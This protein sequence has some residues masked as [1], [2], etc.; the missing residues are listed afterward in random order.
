[1]ALPTLTELLTIPTQDEVLDGE[2][3]PELRA[4]GVRVTDWLPGGVYRSMSYAVARLRLEARKAIAAY[5]AAAF[6]DYVFGFVETPFGIDVTS[7]ATDIA[8]NV[9]GI[10]RIA[11][12]RTKRTITLTNATATPYGPVA[13]GGFIVQL[14]SGNRYV[15]AE[16]W[17]S[18][19]SDAVEVAFESEYANDSAAGLVY[20][21][22]P[23]GATITIVSANF[24]GVTA[25]N[26]AGT[27][28]ARTLVGY[29]LGTVTPSG[30]PGAGYTTATFSVR[31]DSTGQTGAATWSYRIQTSTADTGWVSAGAVAAVANASGSGV[32]ITLTNHATAN[33]S[34][35]AGDYYYFA[36]PGTDIT[37]TGRDEETPLELG[38]RCRAVFPALAFT[39]D[40]AGNWIWT[41]PTENAYERLAREASTQVKVAYARNST[42][43][44]NKVHVLVAGQ[45]T[46]LGAGTVATVQA[47]LDS[48][49]MLTDR[50]VVESPTQ[51]AITLAGMTVTVRASQVTAAQTEIQRR[52]A[53]YLGGVDPASV[54][55]INGRVDRAYLL[56]LIRTA[57]GVVKVT[58]ST[59]TI[60]GAAA[61]LELPVTPGAYELAKWTQSVSLA[62]T[63]ATQA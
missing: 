16:A 40:D 26:P 47:F 24:P 43:V 42:T 53:A 39:Q 2:V 63:W 31:V 57:P 62:F 51:R 9:Y 12:T 58:D 28:T 4:R 38:T 6:G 7:W 45:G 23:S 59:L 56:H 61:D 13:P 55:S 46:V 35:L 21:T 36:T 60:N 20:N 15:N 32:T 44:N 22:D 49:A 19:G 50:V 8:R 3:L 11:A 29:G 33:P 5:T 41:S 37:Q 10:E 18:A 17:S 14:P 54:L 25:T 34:F 1:M 52:I 27:Y 30:T 48:R